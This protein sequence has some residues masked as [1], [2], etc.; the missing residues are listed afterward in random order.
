M[1]QPGADGLV[2][3]TL[4]DK[5]GDLL[6]RQ[7]ISLDTSLQDT[8]EFKTQLAF[9]IPRESDSA[10]LSVT[11]LDQAQ[12]PIAVRTAALTLQSAGDTKIEPAGLTGPWLHID[13]PEPGVVI[14]TSPLVV[15]GQVMPIND[16]PVIFSLVTERGGAVGG[17]QLAVE[18]PREP[19]DFEILLPFT[20]SST[21]RDMRLIIRQ[22]S[23]V[24]G[25]YAILDSL[26]ITIEP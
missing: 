23:N 19:V 7:V 6:S 22:A 17:R 13:Q 11:T 9:E 24:N 3:V 20:P 8:V 12:R 4:V 2:R 15:K 5:Q 16:Y 18:T 10:I 26:L 14:N 1:V 25:V 21:V